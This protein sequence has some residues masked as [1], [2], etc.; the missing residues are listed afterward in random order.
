MSVHQ[1]QKIHSP[2][3][4]LYL[5]L[6]T[7]MKADITSVKLFVHKIIQP[8]HHTSQLWW[9]TVPSN[10]TKKSVFQSLTTIQNHGTQLGLSLTSSWA[11]SPSGCKMR[12]LLVLS[13]ISKT[14]TKITT[15]RKLLI[16]PEKSFSRTRNSKN[17]LV[18]TSLSLVSTM[19]RK[20]KTGSHSLKRKKLLRKLKLK[21]RP[22]P[23]LK[24]KLL[25]RQ[26]LLRKLP[27]PKLKRKPKRP[28]SQRNNLKI[29]SLTS[30]R[31]LF[32]NSRSLKK[33]QSQWRK[34]SQHSKTLSKPRMT[35]KT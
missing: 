16:N 31:K 6:L 24:L 25:K 33:F 10:Q 28:K 22:R 4:S 30:L 8:D 1:I 3:T 7:N 19:L 27:K 18:S 34:L 20:L 13:T 21:L 29:S 32:Q 35:Y 9:T 17:V 2:G 12:K 23:L 14:M 26:K 5:V 15:E 11:A